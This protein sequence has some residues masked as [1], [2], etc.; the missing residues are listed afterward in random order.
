M[1]C[2]NI[3]SSSYNPHSLGFEEKEN[4]KA[5]GFDYC[6]L[7]FDFK[8]M[9]VSVLQWL[10]NDDFMGEILNSGKDFY[11]AIW[12]ILT[13]SSCNADRRQ[14]CKDFFLPVFYGAGADALAQRLKWPSESCKTLINRIHK[15]LPMAS[16]WILNQQRKSN[17]EAVDCYARRR[18][19]DSAH[20]VRN[21]VVQSPASLV[22]LHKLVLLMQA[23]G[24]LA[25]V[26]MHIHDGYVLSVKKE[27]LFKTY[28]LTKQILES[29]ND[30]YPGLKLKTGCKMGVNLNELILYP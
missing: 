15:T 6:F 8:H 7:S 3:F 27:N 11:E 12:E 30:L 22:C 14:L 20:K 2:S 23:L 19:F 10:S 13:Q 1:K 5:P 18:S 21:F 9:E 29:E 25:A 4:L 24:D 28:K 17:G 16:N 26:C